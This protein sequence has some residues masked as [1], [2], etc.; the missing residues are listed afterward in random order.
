VEFLRCKNSQAIPLCGIAVYRLFYKSFHK[1][2]IMK[3]VFKILGIIALV[4][5]I[6]FSMAACDDGNG[7]GGGGQ[8][9]GG[10]GTNPGGGGGSPTTYS[11]E[12]SWAM[13][14]ANNNVG[15]VIKING[16]TGVYTQITTTDP[17]TQS[18]VDKGYI[19]VGGQYIRNLNK[20]GDLTWSCQTLATQFYDSNPNVAIGTVWKDDTIT[21]SANG[22]KLTSSFFGLTYSRLQ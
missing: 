20:P 18:A 6:G 15:I 4:A 10:G 11:I 12:G 14:D 13:Y 5:I 7:A 22:Q 2:F 8:N 3:K 1:E 21:M 16:S 9:P 17:L 19:K